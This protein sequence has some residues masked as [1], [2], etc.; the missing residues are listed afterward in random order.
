MQQKNTSVVMADFVT[1]L[2]LFAQ[3]KIKYRWRR[4]GQQAQVRHVN[5]N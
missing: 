4:A 2:N 1:V 3:W 5:Q